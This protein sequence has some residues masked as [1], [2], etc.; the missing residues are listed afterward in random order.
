MLRQDTLIVRRRE[1]VVMKWASVVVPFV[2][3]AGSASADPPAWWHERADEGA[4][5]MKDHEMAASDL[6]VLRTFLNV[7]DAELAK[8]V[9]DAA[10]LRSF[11]RA[12][13][14]GGMRPHFWMHGV[15]LLVR[16]EDLEEATELLGE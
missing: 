8:S 11:I 1:R 10:N 15:Q 5:G 7:I 12:D 14:A 16:A 2:V 13:D 9:L 4:A 3:D 6:V